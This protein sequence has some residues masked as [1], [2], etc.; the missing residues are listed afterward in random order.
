MDIPLKTIL[1]FCLVAATTTDPPDAVYYGLSATSPNIK[2]FS[3]APE[4]TSTGTFITDTTTDST[5]DTP[6]STT[7][8]TATTTKQSP[9]DSSPCIGD[10]TCEERLGGF[11]VCICQPGLV[12]LEIR[13]CIQTKVF[14]GSLS[15]N[16]DY[17]QDMADKMSKE[18]QQIAGEIEKQLRNILGNDNGY[19]NSIVLS[20]SGSVIAEVQNFYDLSSSATSDSVGKKIDDAISEIINATNYTRGSMCD[21]DICDSTTTEACEEQVASGTVR[22]TCKE[23]YIRSQFTSLFCHR[24]YLFSYLLVVTVVSTVL[25]ALL[26]IFIVA[27]IVVSCRNQKGSSSSQEDFSSSYGN[28][29]L[30]KPTGVPRIP[31]ANPDAGWKSNNLE[32]TDSGSN[33]AL[34]TRDRPESKARY[35]DYDEDVSNRG[36]VPPAYSGYGGRGVE[37]GGVHNPYFRQDD[38]R[39]RRY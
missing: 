35:T 20:L 12:Y 33:Q 34:V 14:P 31:R 27:L 18:F 37:N 24:K 32:M 1:I 11:F 22:C 2:P 21:I 28:K 16:R 17:N 29:E 26:I 6:A 36:Q 3:T 25:G 19:I 9:C 13:G 4:E 23:G 8:A 38:D 10:S 7:A 15:L 39:M 30:H 5:D